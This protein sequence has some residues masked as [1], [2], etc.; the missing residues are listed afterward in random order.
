MISS[1]VDFPQP[2]GPTTTKNSPRVKVE[3][4]R[5]ERLDLALRRG[6]RKDARDAAQRDVDL[7]HG[8]WVFRLRSSGR[9]LSSM[10]LLQSGSSLS[11]PTSFCARIISFIAF[12]LISPAPQ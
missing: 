12:R 11:A 9:K 7:R 3:V 6:R 1:S 4:D 2:E 5:P 10:I 8:Y